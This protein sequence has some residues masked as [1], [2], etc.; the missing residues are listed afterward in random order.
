[1]TGGAVT[2]SFPTCIFSFSCCTES[3]CSNEYW[4][5]VACICVGDLNCLHDPCN[6]GFAK[7]TSGGNSVLIKTWCWMV[8]LANLAPGCT[9]ARNLDQ[10][11]AKSLWARNYRIP[12]GES[13]DITNDCV[14][15]E[16]TVWRWALLPKAPERLTIPLA[17]WHQSN[18]R[19]SALSTCCQYNS[20]SPKSVCDLPNFMKVFVVTMMAPFWHL[21][22]STFILFCEVKKTRLRST[23]D[24]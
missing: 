6:V 18:Q 11:S 23:S 9:V 22:N 16:R 14:V 1:M 24:H 2:F 4:W 12:A 21:V 7:W 13:D 10:G 8:S 3:F 19:F 17:T 15:T 5:G 20:I